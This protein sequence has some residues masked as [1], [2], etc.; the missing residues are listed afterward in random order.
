[1][2]SALVAWLVLSSYLSSDAT[3]VKKEELTP[4][5]IKAEPSEWERY[6]PSLTEG[7]SDTSRTFPT[8]GRHIPLHFTGREESARRE[9]NEGERQVDEVI[10]STGLQPLIAEADDEDEGISTPGFRDS[11]I[12]TS[13]DEI[14][15]GRVQRRKKN[16]LVANLSDEL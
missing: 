8:L 12:G 15:R 14:Q 11:G 10:R 3:K 13:L 16:P 4:R 9:A 2:F 6:E 1:M 7:L 5:K